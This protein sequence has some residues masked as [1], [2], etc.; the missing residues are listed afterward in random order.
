MIG[1]TQ[2]EKLKLAGREGVTTKEQAVVLSS[3]GGDAPKLRVLCIPEGK[4]G[5]QCG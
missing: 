2:K 3:G 1:A 4:P 5:G